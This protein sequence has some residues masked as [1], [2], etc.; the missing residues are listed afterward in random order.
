[1]TDRG[2]ALVVDDCSD[3]REELQELLQDSGFEVFVAHDRPT[4]LSAL[5]T[6][7][8][9]VAVVDVNLSDKTH[10]V[11]GLLINRYIQ[12]KGIDTRVILVSA[13]PLTAQELAHAHPAKFVEKSSIWNQ[14]YVLLGETDRAQVDEEDDERG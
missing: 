8:F 14:L 2:R 11:D 6:Q 10:N 7:P 3:W 1:M 4:A 5:D 13:R 9:D 12:D